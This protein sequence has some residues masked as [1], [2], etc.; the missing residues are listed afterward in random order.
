MMSDRHT[1][2]T[3]N[4]GFIPGAALSEHLARE[5]SRDT[6]PRTLR[7]LRGGALGGNISST[8]ISDS[9]ISTRANTARIPANLWG[10]STASRWRSLPFSNCYGFRW[11]SA[12]R[13][14]HGRAGTRDRVHHQSF[15]S[16]PAT[17]P[18]RIGEM[19][20]GRRWSSRGNLIT[21]WQR[22]CLHLG[23]GHAGQSIGQV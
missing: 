10:Q 5:S 9:N 14:T 3:M 1:D 12:S 19:V 2:W 7:I 6:F 16:L 18:W 13:P 21:N 20:R 11:A 22:P 4:A 8:G 17:F 23:Y 15:A